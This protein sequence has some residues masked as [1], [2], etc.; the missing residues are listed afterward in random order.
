MYACV[1]A[2]IAFKGLTNKIWYLRVT[3]RMYFS[4]DV[5]DIRVFYLVNFSRSTFIA[6]IIFLFQSE[7]SDE[8]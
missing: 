2:F 6:C 4:V 5:I 1:Y 8:T 7:E 3:R